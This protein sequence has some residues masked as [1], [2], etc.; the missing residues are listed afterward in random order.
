[1]TKKL[2]GTTWESPGTWY[3]ADLMGSV[4][5]LL[6]SSWVVLVMSLV[7]QLLSET[8]KSSGR[9]VEQMPLTPCRPT[10]N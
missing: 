8:F 9:P 4:E 7:Q 2:K 1:M 10:A 5:R 3:V 6:E